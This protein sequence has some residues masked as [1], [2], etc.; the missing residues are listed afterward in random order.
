MNFL[1][2][3]DLA[4]H[5]ITL[6]RTT[7]SRF[8]HVQN[9]FNLFLRS[10]CFCKMFLNMT[11]IDQSGEGAVTGEF[12]QLPKFED[13]HAERAEFLFAA[14]SPEHLNDVNLMIKSIIS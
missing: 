10:N 13:L 6:K 14:N 3:Q 11:E 8:L 1:Q 5:S 12:E 4:A 7:F 2:F 9:A